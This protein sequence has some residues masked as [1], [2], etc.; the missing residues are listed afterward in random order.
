MDNRTR[1]NIAKIANWIIEYFEI[2]V[3][4]TDMD[5]VVAKLGGKV[6]ESNSPIFMDIV[7]KGTEEEGVSFVVCI[8]KYSSIQRRN[9]AIAHE[10]GHLFMHMGYMSNYETWEACD[11]N[12]SLIGTCHEEFE[13]HE[14]ASAFLMPR[15]QYFDFLY[16]H[17]ENNAVSTQ[18]IANHF[19]V[20][21]VEA[22]NRG[23]WL[24]VLLW[25]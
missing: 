11:A 8:S 1:K 3:P 4:I 6:E 22:V 7:R 5:M 10:I 16:D 15:Q 17:K 13:A 12:A 20:P 2:Q 14:F 23:K 9:F 24:E 19:L 18:V 25:K 21:R